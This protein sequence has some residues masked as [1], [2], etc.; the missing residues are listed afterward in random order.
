MERSW[1][2]HLRLVP[3]L[4]DLRIAATAHRHVVQLLC[5][6]YILLSTRCTL[7]SLHGMT[8]HVNF[9]ARVKL[10]AALCA[11]ACSTEAH[12]RRESRACG[13]MRLRVQHQIMHWE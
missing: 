3:I 8:P 4:G 11:R 1:P 2:P 7:R 5:D 9:G 12:A 6:V 13:E 10:Q